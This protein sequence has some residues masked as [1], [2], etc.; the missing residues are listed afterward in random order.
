METRKVQVV[1]GTT[2]TVSLPK[3]WSNLTKLKPGDDLVLVPR[4]PILLVKPEREIMKLSEAEIKADLEK[5]RDVLKLVISS[6]LVGHRTIKITQVDSDTKSLISN[7]S[8]RFMGSEISEESQRELTLTT[9]LSSSALKVSEGI[10]RM[11][12]I[13]SV[14][15]EKSIRAFINADVDLAKDTMR[16]DDEA[17][18]LNLFII[19]QLMV[20]LVEDDV[21]V[22]FLQEYI[23]YRSIVK[24]LEKIGD[25]AVEI[26]NLVDPE[27][28]LPE[29]LCQEFQ[30]LSG[31]SKETYSCAL[32]SFIRNDLKLASKA[33]EHREQFN[34][35]MK[36]FLDGC[37]KETLP[38]CELIRLVQVVHILH[39]MTAKGGSM[40]TETFNRYIVYQ[41]QA[42]TNND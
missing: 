21:G 3:T 24:D 15:H 30:T 22:D 17:D 35:K 39:E 36:S 11:L 27:I 34:K 2:L 5:G 37:V 41:L 9:L 18:R 6:F 26:A 14:M 38:N 29:Q 4:G 42:S 32:E 7:N 40:A 12:R 10:E 8:W 23:I 1:G 28:K 33:F 25:H 13:A 31:M 20:G 19:R 16:Q